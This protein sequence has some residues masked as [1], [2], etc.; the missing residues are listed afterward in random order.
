MLT[1]EQF[2]SHVA[3]ATRK[4]REASD[5]FHEAYAGATADQRKDLKQRWM[6]GHL[7]GQQV[8]NP[9]RVLSE[10]KG[11]GAKPEN[12]RAIDRAYSDF[13]YYVVR[14]EPKQAS[15]GKTDPVAKALALVAE[16]TPAQK[17]R[18]MAAL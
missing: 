16:M 1:I 7:I 17:K 14:P 12:V 6:L 9:E 8:K 4:I 15:S 2:A 10:G 5:S 11:D 3:A 18:F 13:R